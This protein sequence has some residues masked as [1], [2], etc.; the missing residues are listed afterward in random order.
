MAFIWDGVYQYEDFDETNT[1]NYILKDQIT[2]NGNTR[3]S[4]QPGDIK[5]RDINGDKVVDANDYAI[6]EEDCLFIQEASQ[7]SSRIRTSI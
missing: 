5:F 6:I 3:A 2:T 7:M 4:I 1:G